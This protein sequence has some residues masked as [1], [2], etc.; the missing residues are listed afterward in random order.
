[1]VSDHDM[2]MRIRLPRSTPQRRPRVTEPEKDLSESEEN[3]RL[4]P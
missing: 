3:L 2:R 4:N 1:V